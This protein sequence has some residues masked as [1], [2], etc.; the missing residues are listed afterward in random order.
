MSSDPDSAISDKELLKLWRDPT[1]SLSYRGARSFQILLKTD[2]DISVSLG[3]IYRVLRQDPIYL[4]HKKPIRN[5]TRRFYYLTHYCEVLQMDLASMYEY[6]GYNYFLLVVDIFSSK[7][8]A[9]ALKDKSSYTTALALKKLLAKFGAVPSMIECDQGKEFLGDVKKL[10]TKEHIV[11][12]FKYGKNKAAIIEHYIYLLKKR[13]FMLLRGTLSKNWVGHLEKICDDM[14]KTPLKRLGWL[15]PSDINT[16]RDSILVNE[17]KKAHNIPILKEPSFEEQQQKQKD[18]ESSTKNKFQV[19][20]Y[21]L[22]DFKETPLFD[23]SFDVSVK[24]IYH[25][26]LKRKFQRKFS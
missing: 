26:M 9:Q 12:K 20:S 11:L 1:L 14:N 10:L 7:I 24:K 8:Y 4:Q 16:F 13:L 5:F 17:E 2:L 6:D 3:R 15:K 18:Y 23:K 19:H 25:F 22:L 21:V